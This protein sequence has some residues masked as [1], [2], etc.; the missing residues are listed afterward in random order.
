VIVPPPKPKPAKTLPNLGL[1]IVD[2]GNAQPVSDTYIGRIQTRQY[3][4]PEVIIGRRDWDR[5]VD[6]WSIAC[7]VFEL[8]TGDYLFDPPDGSPN[9][10][11]DHICQVISL[12]N[13]HYDRRW[14]MGGRQSSR[15]FDEYGQSPVP[16]LR[17]GFRANNRL[18]IGDIPRERRL[19][20]QTLPQRLEEQYHLEPKLAKELSDFLLPMLEFEPCNRATAKEM[21]E[22]PWLANTA[23]K[24]TT[25]PH[26][27]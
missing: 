18:K 7:I 2:F 10:D 25:F 17:Y 24:W 19:K 22:H 1:K 11:Q 16:L 27:A 14:V 13:P 21:G 15:I 5:K 3:R 20:F 4:A 9:K 26:V 8:A 23:F 12:T 6:V